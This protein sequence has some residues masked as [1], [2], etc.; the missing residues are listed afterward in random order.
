MQ[1][2]ISILHL[3]SGNPLLIQ[4]KA[5]GVTLSFSLMALLTE[6]Q[7]VN[8]IEISHCLLCANN[9]LTIIRIWPADND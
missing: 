7:A 4:Q 6:T 2:G 5:E 3:V 8:K 9:M 1:M